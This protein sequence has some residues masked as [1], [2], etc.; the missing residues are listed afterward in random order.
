VRF[1]WATR[2][3]T[4]GFRFLRRA[5]LADPLPTYSEAFAEFEGAAQVWSGIGDV[6]A[7]RFEDPLGR[8]DRA[9]RVIPHD[10]VIFDGAAIGARS[11]LDAMEVVWPLVEDEYARMSTRVS[12]I[13]PSQ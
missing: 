10:F 13:C 5:G 6:T 2:G 1:I 8:E 7:L 9:G 4:W 12:T 11:L 3:R